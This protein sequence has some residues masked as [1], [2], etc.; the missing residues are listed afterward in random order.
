M[1]DLRSRLRQ[2]DPLLREGELPRVRSQRLREQI[3]SVRSS[4]TSAQSRFGFPIAA[5]LLS[6]AAGSAWLVRTSA[7]APAVEYSS[8]RTRQ[9]QFSTSGGTRVIW[10]FN[11]SFELR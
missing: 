5:V 6:M 8:L 4:P 11:D 1:R 9:L 7:P 3:L 10:T 2:A